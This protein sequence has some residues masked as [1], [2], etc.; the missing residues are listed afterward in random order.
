MSSS[1]RSLFRLGLP[2]LLLAFVAC[3]PEPAPIEVPP[4]ALHE[5]AV[6]T[7]AQLCGE[8]LRSWA[9][10]GEGGQLL[11]VT[12]GRCLGSI[13]HPEEGRLWHLVA[14]LQDRDAP[15]PSWELHTWIDDEGHP[16]HAEFRT[17]AVVTRYRWT[18]TGLQLWR[19]GDQLELNLE[20]P[21]SLW[22][23]PSH[24]LFLREVM[25]RLGVGVDAGGVH[26]RTWLPEQDSFAEVSMALELDGDRGQA[27]IG[28]SVLGLEGL[29][30][31]LAGL[32]ID[33]VMAGDALL[34][35]PLSA[36]QDR[37][38]DFL[39]A[40]PRPRYQAGEDL[41]LVPVTIPAVGEQPALAGELV[42]PRRS[43]QEAGGPLPAVLFLAGA[44]PQDRHGIVPDSPVD[45]GSHEIEDALARAGFAVLRF[46]DRGVGDSELGDDPT[47]GFDDL[48]DDGRRALAVLAGRPEV[49]PRRIIVIGHGE[50]ALHASILAGERRRGPG[51]ILGLVLLAAPGRNLRELIYDE[52]RASMVGEAE[53]RVRL[54]VQQ[55]QRVHDAALAGEELPASSEGAR[56]WMVQAFAEDP[57]A[58]LRAVK[59]PVLALQGGKDFQ[60]SPERDFAAVQG[61]LEAKGAKGSKVVLLEGLDHLFKPEGGVS[62]PG[63][64]GDL[65]R[66]VDVGVIEEVCGWALERVR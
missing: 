27:R 23:T 36:E 19:L 2:A 57:L 17:A 55:A 12:R 60:V 8:S 33:M 22:L 31:G 18:E 37:L 65:G 62:T 47:P 21:G 25:L 63:H 39:P 50:G 6:V 3:R 32:H 35:R 59:V 64:Y 7:P 5:T 51:K 46:D 10:L 1:S 38:A 40:V 44:G 52:I 15:T 4:P 34:Y 26:Q 61:V 48:V 11:A 42:L 49:D 53:G 45:M 13:D 29:A 43:E 20:Q 9:V 28:S 41:E 16:R 58:R 56:D 66:R 24:G 54:V 14:Q 30:A